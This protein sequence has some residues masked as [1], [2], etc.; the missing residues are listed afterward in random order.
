MSVHGLRREPLDEVNGADEAA[1]LLRR[2]Q[3]S[4][5]L[6]GIWDLKKRQ[7]MG[8]WVVTAACAVYHTR[9]SQQQDSPGLSKGSHGLRQARLEGLRKGSHGL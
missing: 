7:S 6:Q 5:Q 2:T 8:P 9:C 3:E 1:A 4:H